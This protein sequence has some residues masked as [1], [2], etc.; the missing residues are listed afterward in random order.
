MHNITSEIILL[1]LSG[2][3]YFELVT[4]TLS[5]V[6]AYLSSTL[7][8]DAKTMICTPYQLGSIRS[9]LRDT[10]GGTEHAR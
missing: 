3:C 6:Y 8:L 10:F 5:S 2:L 7:M 1:S 9:V 4:T